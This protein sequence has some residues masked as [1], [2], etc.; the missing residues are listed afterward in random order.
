MTQYEIDNTIAHINQMYSVVIDKV[1]RVKNC[2]LIVGL[3]NIYKL[4]NLLYL[5]WLYT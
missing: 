2:I 5:D 3:G 4:Y 1:S